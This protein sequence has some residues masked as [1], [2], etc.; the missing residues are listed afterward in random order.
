MSKREANNTFGNFGGKINDDLKENKKL[1]CKE[2]RKARNQ[3][4][5]TSVNIKI[6]LKKYWWMIRERTCEEKIAMSCTMRID[7][8]RKNV[9]WRMCIPS[10]EFVEPIS[11]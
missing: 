9:K 3:E 7:K 8:K 4:K 1:F 10:E 5:N 11:M 2:V 6:Q